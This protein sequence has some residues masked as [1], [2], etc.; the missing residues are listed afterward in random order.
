MPIL[1][2]DDNDDRRPAWWHTAI[3]WLL[4]VGWASWIGY[5]L[6]TGF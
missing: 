5:T 6:I 4:L 1:W 2:T 3:G